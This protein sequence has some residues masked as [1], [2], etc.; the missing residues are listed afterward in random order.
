[1]GCTVALYNSQ[2]IVTKFTA[3][4]GCLLAEVEQAFS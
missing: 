3:R 2:L 1:M 4:K